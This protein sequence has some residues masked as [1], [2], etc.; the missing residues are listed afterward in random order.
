MNQELIAQTVHRVHR[1]LRRGHH[2]RA[3]PGLPELVDSFDDYLAGEAHADRVMGLVHGD[4]RLDNML[5]GRRGSRRDLT[6]VDW[7]TVSWGPA[8]TDVAYFIGCAL[9]TEDRR[10]HYERTAAAYHEGWAQIRRSPSRM[11]ARAS[12]V[13][14][15][16]GDDGGGLGDARRT[17]RARRRDVPHDGGPPQQP[18]PGHRRARHPA[19]RRAQPS[20]QPDPADEA[21]HTPATSRCGTRAGTGTSPIPNRASAAG[22]G[23]GWCPTRTWPGSTR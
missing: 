11:S 10:A 19:G 7:Q 1:A 5:F 8:M 4:Y 21:A 18:R 23:W 17:H 16:R 22:S 20:L 6:V 9:R 15:L 13:R 2:T 3:A 12:G 14:V